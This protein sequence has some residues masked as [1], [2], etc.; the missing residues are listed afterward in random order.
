MDEIL[1]QLQLY[2]KKKIVK[3]LKETQLKLRIIKSK[4]FNPSKWNYEISK[5]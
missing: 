1:K 5:L 2:I 3:D 4:Q